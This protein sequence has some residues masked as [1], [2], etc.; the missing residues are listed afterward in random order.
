MLN[1]P[2]TPSRRNTG[3]AVQEALSLV[4]PGGAA[5]RDLQVVGEAHL[6]SSMRLLE[7]KV[8]P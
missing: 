7:V 8:T 3:P 5:R 1:V 4:T 6:R 2:R